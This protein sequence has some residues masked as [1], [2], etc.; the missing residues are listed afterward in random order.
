MGLRVDKNLVVL[1]MGIFSILIAMSI[2]VAIAI[3]RMHTNIDR[4]DSVVH[5][6]NTKIAL[7]TQ[8]GFSAR[9]RTLIIFRILAADD[10]FDRDELMLNFNS[11]G[12][13]FV[14][15][16]MTLLSMDLSSREKELLDEQARVTNDTVPIQQDIVDMA[17]TDNNDE[18]IDSLL[19]I[20]IPKQ[21]LVLETLASLLS[22][23]Q[24]SANKALDQAVHEY[25]VAVITLGLLAFSVFI[26]CIIIAIYVI[27]HTTHSRHLLYKEKELAQITLHSIGDGVITTDA[28][29]YIEHIN[30]IAEYLTGWTID[31]AKGVLN[32]DVCKIKIGS[33]STERLDP[34]SSVI[35]SKQI[36]SSDGNAILQSKNG[37]EFAIEYTASPIFNNEGGV[38]GTILVFKNVTETRSLNN[39]LAY[40]AKHDALTKLINRAEFE[41]SVEFLINE[42]RQTEHEHV[43][44]YLD[45]DQFK[46][47]NDTCGHYAGD[48]LIKQLAEKFKERVRDS[49]IVG[50]LGGDEFGILFKECTLK[51]ANELM[52][53]IRQDIHSTHFSWDDKSFNVSIS[54]GLVAINNH[55]ESLYELLSA[56]DNTCYAAKDDGRNRIHTYK[57]DDTSM[58]GRMG[59]MQWVHRLTKALKDNRFL[60]Y[61]HPIQ[62]LKSDS[63][64]GNSC[65][66]LVRMED[67]DGKIIPPM[68]FI[69]AAERYNLMSDIDRWVAGNVLDFMSANTDIIDRLNYSFSINISAQSLSSE[70]FLA[71]IQEKIVTSGV[72]PTRLCFEITETTAIAN[73]S[74]AQKFIS[75]LKLLGC[76]FSLDDF[77]S[78][79]SSFAYLKN[80]HVD[81]LK[82]DGAF[83]RNIADD[84]IDRA[85]VSSINQVGH[86]IGIE[87]IA[88]Y[89]ETKEIFEVLKDIGVDYVQGHYLGMPVPIEGLLDTPKL[90]P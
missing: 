84:E 23:Q 56:A 64:L 39:A 8:M 77:G 47:V 69:P 87:T 86:L 61:H 38:D 62:P 70:K 65:E 40:Q 72:M 30:S 14:Q 71:Y 17:L 43:P 81:Y 13:V 11:E 2:V 22:I 7:V 29:G 89:V 60:L 28:D 24:G 41:L 26:A 27:R 75:T 57:E 18:N 85:M 6:Q 88:E 80:L 67:E 53:V 83:I 46:V 82:I 20:A 10:P 79:L 44:C 55:S 52:E 51:K 31:S 59:E 68:A 3:D 50:R 9:E 5:V 49:D 74:R 19:E 58:K 21:D 34:I 36:F 73:L 78:G 1:T 48:E 42:A 32:R 12:S 16:R 15:A 33:L 37:V 76:K 4:I 45:I 35:N 66:I 63:S 25:Q 54:A 90:D